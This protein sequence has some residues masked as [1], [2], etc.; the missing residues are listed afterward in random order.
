MSRKCK[1][2]C[3]RKACVNMHRK[4]L[5][6]A[7]KMDINPTKFCKVL[8][9][10]RSTVQSVLKSNDKMQDCREIN[11]PSRALKLNSTVQAGYA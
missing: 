1:N 6:L 7:L 10:L 3:V 11:S 5:S 2:I 9:R 4:I 8:E